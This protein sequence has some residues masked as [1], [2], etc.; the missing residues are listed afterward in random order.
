[1]SWGEDHLQ[2]ECGSHGKPSLRFFLALLPDLVNGAHVVEAHLGDVVQ[3]AAQIGLKALDSLRHGHIAALFAGE[4][5]GHKE[6]LG[7]EPLDF[8]GPG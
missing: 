8:A 1:M 4:G 2:I 5:L 3:L 6:G 7:E